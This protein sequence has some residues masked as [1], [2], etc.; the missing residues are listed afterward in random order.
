[1]TESLRDLLETFSVYRWSY[2]A[3]FVLSYLGD[4]ST[5]SIPQSPSAVA[6]AAAALSG[7]ALTNHPLHAQQVP[8]DSFYP[9]AT[10]R[11]RQVGRSSRA[12]V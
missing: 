10:W 8:L 7:L 9:S 11:V 6:A 3:A 2:L 1:M 4:I 12:L 5:S